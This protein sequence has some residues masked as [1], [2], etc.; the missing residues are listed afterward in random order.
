M[1]KK[2]PKESKEEIVDYDALM[3]EFITDFF[4]EFIA[5][6]NP[7][8]YEAI[9]W[10]KGVQFL[11]QELLNALKGRFKS[12]GKRKYTDK[13]V[14]VYLLNGEAHYIFIHIEF[15]HKPEPGFPQ[16]MYDYRSLIYLRYGIERISAIA[17][18]TGAPPAFNERKYFTET[19][20]AS[21]EYQY[22]NLVAVEQKETVLE[23]SENPIA[24]ALLA[25][26]YTYETADNPQER[27][28]LKKKLSTLCQ[29]RNI[30]LEKIVKLLTFVRDFISLPPK[31]ENEFQI[32]Q[33]AL[34]FTKSEPM[35]ATQGSKEFA[36]RIY[37]HVYGFKPS[38]ALK[39]YKRKLAKEEKERSRI[40]EELNKAEEGRTQAEE[41]RIRAEEERTRAEEEHLVAV[42]KLEAERKHT[43]LQL[44]KE[45]SFSPSQIA[46]FMELPEAYIVDVISQDENGEVL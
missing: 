16:R 45:L 28:N 27:L 39:A 33:L 8:L 37:A 1:P 43:I 24:L 36:E 26:K 41:E 20:G 44:H 31:L 46:V 12:K 10:S 30:P 14:K 35:P 40:A 11:E 21:I 17:V 23:A 18:F 29:Q 3:K 6:V 19:F 42:Q 34:S 38:E 5:F 2:A 7:K 13:L 9:D 22:L 4:P 32:S 15:Q 25:A